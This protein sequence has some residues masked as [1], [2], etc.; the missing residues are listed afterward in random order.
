MKNPFSE[1]E[2]KI[3]QV[4]FL[5]KILP[6]IINKFDRN[7]ILGWIQISITE[8]S[9]RNTLREQTFLKLKP[10]NQERLLF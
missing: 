8:T 9:I 2:S 3:R 6:N 4:T 5:E 1:S 7:S 10:G